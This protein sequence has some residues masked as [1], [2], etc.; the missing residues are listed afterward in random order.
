VPPVTHSE[1]T[2]E[3]ILE[4]DNT[5]FENDLLQRLLDRQDPSPAERA[6][7]LVLLLGIEVADGGFGQFY[8]N[9]DGTAPVETPGALRLIGAAQHAALVDEANACFGPDGPP[10]DTAARR[11]A[12]E[13][14]G[15]T[16][17][18]RWHE[19]DSLYYGLSEDLEA[20][21]RGYVRSHRDDFLDDTTA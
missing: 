1:P 2:L 4:D 8:Y 14:L 3:Q 6:S 13:A 11:A 19:L 18:R 10:A 16:A 21:L 15:E 12:I 17:R 7:L 20:L 9:A 5:F